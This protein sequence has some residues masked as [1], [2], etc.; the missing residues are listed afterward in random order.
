VRLVFLV[1]AVEDLAAIRYFIAENNPEAAK[2]VAP[3]L[4]EII[5]RLT[6]MP[7][8]GKPGRVRNLVKLNSYVFCR[9]AHPQ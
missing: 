1:T 5:K 3:R 4:K 6:I 9:S 8:L 2:E 7:N